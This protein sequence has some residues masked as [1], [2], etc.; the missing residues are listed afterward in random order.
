MFTFAGG[1][2]FLHNNTSNDSFLKFYGVQC[3]PVVMASMNEKDYVKIF[4]SVSFNC[5]GSTLFADYVFDEQT[6]CF[7]YIPIG[8]WKEKEHI[9]YAPFFR[10]MV[11]FPPTNPDELYR[12]MLF[13]GKRI[14]GDQAICRFVQKYEELGTYFQLSDISYLFTNSHPIK[15]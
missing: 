1:V 7:S 2:P 4:G 8:Q 11:T 13:D 3:E 6:N 14:F 12:S 9:T 10:N 5:H 15:P